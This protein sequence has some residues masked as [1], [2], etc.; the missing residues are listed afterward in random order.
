MTT[1]LK[2]VS[3]QDLIID[4]A[5]RL[6]KPRGILESVPRDVIFYHIK[7]GLMHAT[8]TNPQLVISTRLEEFYSVNTPCMQNSFTFWTAHKA[9]MK[10]IVIQLASRLKKDRNKKLFQLIKLLEDKI[11]VSPSSALYKPSKLMDR[12]FAAV[13]HK[14]K[15]PFFPNQELTNYPIPKTSPINLVSSTISYITW[16]KTHTWAS[17]QHMTLTHF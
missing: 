10:R 8:R 5:H 14:M 3:K 4:R 13:R 9:Y 12:R 2:S 17:P 6:P 1:L 15:I 11:K 7:E 16:K